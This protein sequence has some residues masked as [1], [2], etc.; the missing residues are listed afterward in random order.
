MNSMAHLTRQPTLGL[1]WRSTARPTCACVA[2]GKHILKYVNSVRKKS[3]KIKR[4]V[5]DN[6]IGN[7]HDNNPGTT[8]PADTDLTLASQQGPSVNPFDPR[9]LD[10]DLSDL[11][12]NGQAC[13]VGFSSSSNL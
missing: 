1:L 13:D 11:S 5:G 12:A 7:S 8:V 6:P 2:N 3:R 9:N 10:L 4:I